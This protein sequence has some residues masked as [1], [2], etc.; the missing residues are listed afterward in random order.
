MRLLL[1]LSSKCRQGAKQQPGGPIAR[2]AR[3]GPLAARGSKLQA[4]KIGGPS[5]YYALAHAPSFGDS[6]RPRLVS[7]Y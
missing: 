5:S 4:W 1:D 6:L 3:P 2:D 7:R